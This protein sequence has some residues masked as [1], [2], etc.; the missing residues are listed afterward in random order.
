MR[1]LTTAKTL[2]QDGGV[3][4]STFQGARALGERGHSV[5]V[6]FGRNGPQRA[7]Y[8]AAGIPLHGPVVFDFEPRHALRRL[9]SY[10]PSAAAVRRMKPD[11]LWL[12]RS[13][14]IVW[15]QFVA[16]LTGIRIVCHLR[17]PPNYRRLALLYGKVAHFLAVSEYTR[18]EWIDGGIAP[19]RISVLHNAVRLEDYPMGGDE[20]RSA[21]RRQ[22]GLPQTVPITLFFGRLVAEKGI[23][24]L[25]GAWERVLR[26]NPSALLVLVGD[27]APDPASELG[28]ALRR[29]P[30]AS[31]RWFPQTADVIPYL[32]AADVVT[33]PSLTQEPFGRVVIEAMASGRPVIASRVGG[34]P[35]ILDGPFAEFLVPAGN[36]DQLAGRLSA[37]LGWRDRDPGLGDRCHDRIAERFEQHEQINRLERILEHHRKWKL[38]ERRCGWSPSR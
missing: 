7:D 18:Q 26:T 29:L 27:P 13:E 38:R 16:A 35:E 23:V 20:E 19:S 24:T 17:Q 28:S 31:F 1:V 32:H 15:A 6:M 9:W 12:N 10:L 3:E 22:L 11:V 36:A 4:V 37:V 21:A 14:H 8:E 34:I 5:D 2:A 25:V 30:D 33:L